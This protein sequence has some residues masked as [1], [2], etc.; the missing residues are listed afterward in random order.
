M[1]QNILAF[2][3]NFWPKV[4]IEVPLSVEPPTRR[5]ITPY[6]EYNLCSRSMVFGFLWPIASGSADA[7]LFDC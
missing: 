5:Q 6:F 1:G 7:L 4:E 2:P 3:V